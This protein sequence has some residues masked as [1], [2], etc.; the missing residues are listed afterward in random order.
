MNWSIGSKIWMG[1]GTA[2]LLLLV[3]GGVSYRSLDGLILATRAEAAKNRILVELNDLVASIADAE[4][5][6]RGFIITGTDRFLEPYTRAVSDIDRELL[7]IRTL[8]REDL[9]Q[10]QRIATIE[11]LVADRMAAIK[12]LVNQRRNGDFAAAQKSVLADEGWQ[13][14]ETIRERVAEMQT[15]EREALVQIENDAEASA[16]RA[17]STILFGSLGSFAVL[18]VVAVF[19]VRGITVPV[20]ASVAVLSSASTQL[21][22]TSEEHQRTV[23]EQS[24]AINE[25]TATAAELSASQRQVILTVTSVAQTGESALA[26]T[27]TGQQALLN[28]LQ[29]LAEIK[30]KTETT[31]QRIVALSEKSQQVG[32]IIVT[33]KDI[34]EQTNLLALNAAI[35]AARAGDQGK[36]FAVVASEVR[37]LAERTKKSTDDITQLVEAMQNSTNAAVLATEGTLRT[38]DDG[39]RQAIDAQAVFEN[40]AHQVSETADAIKQIQVSCQQQDSATEQISVAMNQINAGMKQTVAAVDQTVQSAV[41]LNDTATRLKRLVG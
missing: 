35:E 14:F 4:L 19:L 37:K 40:I 6:E 18:V 10:Q 31:A 39:N 28:T 32:R 25:T 17:E 36:G 9:V 24:A 1:F 41:G 21:S 11:T 34:A 38:V 8:T 33:I 29:G 27:H 23:A 20:R 2:L 7:E 12:A 15:H 26:A 30:A 16:L 22:A 13:L 3:I 5:G